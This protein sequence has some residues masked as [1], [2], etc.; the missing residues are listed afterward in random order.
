MPP[1]APQNVLLPVTNTSITVSWSPPAEDGG[2]T[3]IYY[4]VKHS[5]P[6]SIGEFYEPIY[7]PKT[8]IK[9]KFPGLRPFTDYCVR[10][11]AHNGVSDQNP[12]GTHLRTIE[13]CGRTDEGSKQYI[14]HMKHALSSKRCICLFLIYTP[15]NTYR[16]PYELLIGAGA[17][18]DLQCFDRVVVWEQ[19]SRPNGIITG[20]QVTVTEPD[21][22]GFQIEQSFLVMDKEKTPQLPELSGTLN[23]E[24]SVLIQTLHVFRSLT[25]C[26][27]KSV[28]L[29]FVIT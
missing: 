29:I 19:P 5:N 3:D 23:I 10:V 11:T 14:P 13:V 7:L 27:Q 22:T 21:R 9:Y 6:L 28:C 16:I 2:R 17:I 1:S 4:E 15:M 24:V 26:F 12:D 8:T 25:S 18:E 20:Y